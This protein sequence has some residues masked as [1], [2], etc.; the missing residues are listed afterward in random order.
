[1][2]EAVGARFTNATDLKT[3]ALGGHQLGGATRAPQHDL[4]SAFVLAGNTEAQACWLPVGR[5][6]DSGVAGF[7]ARRGRS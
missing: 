1:M 3:E 4:Q 7:T 6:A 2:F 5:H